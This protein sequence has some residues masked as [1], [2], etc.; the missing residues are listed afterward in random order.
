MSKNEMSA[1]RANFMLSYEK[2]RGKRDA[3]VTR[4]EIDAF[5]SSL[6]PG[7]VG[8]SGQVLKYPSW[9]T[10]GDMYR[11]GRGEYALPWAELDAFLVVNPTVTPA[12]LIKKDKKKK[13]E[14]AMESQAV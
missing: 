2:F 11:S 13:E 6:A 1:I 10:N 8:P 4:K 3:T 7:A 9:L 12:S 5:M 14:P